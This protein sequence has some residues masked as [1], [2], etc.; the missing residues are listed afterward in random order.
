MPALRPYVISSA[1]LAA[2]LFS[3]TA[4]A[5]EAQHEAALQRVA[6][7]DARPPLV[8]KAKLDAWLKVNEGKPNPLDAFSAGGRQRFLDGLGFGERGVAT[9]APED[10]VW[11]LDNAKAKAVFTL[12]GLSEDPI[13]QRIKTE[14]VAPAWRGD[15][16]RQ[17]DIDQRYTQ[18]NVLVDALRKEDDFSRARHV[19]EVYRRQFPEAFVTQA[20]KLSNPDLLLLARASASAAG[21]SSSEASTQDLFALIPM[22]EQRGMESRLLISSAQRALLTTG[23]LDDARALAAR[24]PSIDLASIPSVTTP[25]NALPDGPRWW[26]LSG[27]GTQMSAESVD[28]SDTQLLVLAG[29]HFSEDA[30]QDAAADPE[31]APVFAAHA[32]WLGTP[33]GDEDLGAWKDWNAQFP[34][35]PMHLITRR[36]DWPMFPQ[37]NMPTY[38]IVRDGKVIE[39]TTGA[40]RNNPEA[41]VALVAMLRRHGLMPAAGNK[42]ASIQQSPTKGAA[43]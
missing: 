14:P 5:R 3:S 25:V 23:R 32:H 42:T 20:R 18:Y 8:S 16:L 21:E 24:H 28:L 43:D 36:I 4:T 34:N 1:L 22:L 35:S 38:A 7:S 39:Q 11:E 12:F 17:S 33:P 2:A 29:C 19:G 30:A 41:R 27:D 31:L 26:R 15:R 9:L 10:M 13:A 40:W 37:W 6:P